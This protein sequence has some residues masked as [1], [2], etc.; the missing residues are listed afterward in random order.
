MLTACPLWCRLTLFL[1]MLGMSAPHSADAVKRALLVGVGNYVDPRVPD[2][3]GPPHDVTALQAALVQHGGFTGENITTLIDGAATKRGILAELARLAEASRPGDFLLVYLSGHGTSAYNPTQLLSLPHHTGAFVPVDFV[4]SGTA[5]EQLESLIV[6]ADDPRPLLE[7][8]DNRNVRGL[9]LIDSCYS[10]NA[11]RTGFS[12]ETSV[13]RGINLTTG[14]EYS[15]NGQSSD[16]ASPYPYRHLVTLAASSK[17]EVAVDQTDPR[18][19]LD[20]KPHGAFT[21]SLLRTLQEVGSADADH[22]GAVSYGELFAAVRMRVSGAEYA[23]SPQILPFYSDDTENLQG[24]LSF[25]VSQQSGTEKREPTA[26]TPLRV[27][28]EG[29]LPG[30]STAVRNIDG[31]LLTT[32]APD[33][34]AVRA[35]GKLRLLTAAGSLAIA[36][37][38]EATLVQALRQQ[39]WVHQLLRAPNVVQRF[40]IHVHMDGYCGGTLEEGDKLDFSVRVEKKAYLLIVDAAPDGTLR[41]LYP[42][43]ENEL[44]AVQGEQPEH[45]GNIGVQPPFGIDYVVA[46]GFVI[47]PPFYDARLLKGAVFS[48]LD[49]GHRELRAVLQA[50]DDP[51]IARQVV[52]VITIPKSAAGSRG[53]D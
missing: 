44:K 34:R 4:S 10:E 14:L 20:G 45:V 1:L 48:P 39:L 50:V 15:G 52:R 47:P 2:L 8:I 28:V 31:L 42:Y 11:Y 38:T 27:E 17:K 7:E 18:R 5:M 51:N 23:Q 9:L 33:L 35:D 46:A 21:D 3:Q 22:D 29:S 43:H 40:Q 41:V 36:T 6:G 25:S 16:K 37:D 32:E 53:C 13:E 26:G 19:T 30:V 24:Q 49:P 12:P